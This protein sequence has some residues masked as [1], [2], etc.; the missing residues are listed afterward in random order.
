MRLPFSSNGKHKMLMTGKLVCLF[1]NF[2]RFVPLSLSENHVL[3][4][5]TGAWMLVG[6]KSLMSRSGEC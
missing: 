4:Y 3:M 2:I 1:Y 6:R 5:S